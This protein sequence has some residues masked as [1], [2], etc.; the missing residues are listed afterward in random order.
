MSD[1]FTSSEGREY[2]SDLKNTVMDG[3][4]FCSTAAIL[5]EFHDRL[6]ALESTRASG[7]PQKYECAHCGFVGTGEQMSVHGAEHTVKSGA[8]TPKVERFKAFRFRANCDN[9]GGPY[10]TKLPIGEVVA[11]TYDDGSTFIKFPDNKTCVVQQLNHYAALVEH[12]TNSG[13]WD[14]VND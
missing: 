13:V 12:L 9:V 8:P 5:N 10:H 1:R 2:L 6:T 7:E 4:R 14:R 11:K 3:H